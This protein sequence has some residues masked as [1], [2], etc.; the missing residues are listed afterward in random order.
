MC[1]FSVLRWI[2]YLKKFNFYFLNPNHTAYLQTTCS[3]TYILLITYKALRTIQ[4]TRDIAF[5]EVARGHAKNF[6]FLILSKIRMRG[7]F[8][9][10]VTDMMHT[11]VTH[12]YG[13]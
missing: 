2:N 5:Y 6:T 9:R 1:W 3:V 8:D 11:E 13:E 4:G 12:R 7:G 10:E